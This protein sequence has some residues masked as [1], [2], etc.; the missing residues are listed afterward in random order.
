MGKN[1]SIKKPLILASLFIFLLSACLANFG[2]AKE[3]SFLRPE[4]LRSVD[5]GERFHTLQNELASQKRS[6]FWNYKSKKKI[7]KILVQSRAAR[8]AIGIATL[9]A[10]LTFP[11]PSQASSREN[12]I[13][14]ANTANALIGGVTAYLKAPKGKKTDSFLN[15]TMGG[16]ISS[17]TTLKW[18]NLYKT[19]GGPFLLRALNAYG[20]NV[21][22]NASKEEPFLESL[23]NFHYPLGPGILTLKEGKPSHY[24]LDVAES[25]VL[26]GGLVTSDI[27][28]KEFLKGG[29][30]VF[31]YE[32]RFILEQSPSS[33]LELS[34]SIFLNKEYSGDRQYREEVLAHELYHVFQSDRV[35]VGLG[36]IRK[37]N[38][39]WSLGKPFSLRLNLPFVLTASGSSEVSRRW[40]GDHNK[41]PFEIEANLFEKGAHDGG[42]RKI[43]GIAST[44]LNGSI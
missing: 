33:G 41:Q 3:D 28:L 42:V 26:I 36:A 6:Y 34:G 16:Y 32:S 39:E 9:T 24:T 22:M 35:L 23:K 21:V 38:Y 7:K 19:P 30:P 2:W 43:N 8:H 17:Y 4:S 31:E 14:L 15:G 5:G 37:W 12:Q 18:A 44:L 25:A 20:A 13:Q 10:L 1:W 27:R 29:A 11:S 40:S